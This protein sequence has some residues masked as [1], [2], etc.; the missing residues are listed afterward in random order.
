MSKKKNKQ[1]I[2]KCCV[3]SDCDGGRPNRNKMGRNKSKIRV[4][5]Y[6]EFYEFIL[7]G[8]FFPSAD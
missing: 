1:E 5:Y 3:T 4:Y 7:R 6:D 2:M 8:V